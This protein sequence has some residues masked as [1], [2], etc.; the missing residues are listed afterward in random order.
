MKYLVPGQDWSLRENSLRRCRCQSFLS[1][2]CCSCYH[3]H[4]CLAAIPVHLPLLFW[5]KKSMFVF[6]LNLHLSDREA[7]I[8]TVL[9]WQKQLSTNQ[10]HIP[11]LVLSYTHDSQ[12]WV[13]TRLLHISKMKWKKNQAII[14]YFA[15]QNKG[16]TITQHKTK[17]YFSGKTKHKLFLR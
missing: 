2:N 15:V 10:L 1:S 8:F 14:H 3:R 4:C 16:R 5:S 6:H 9:Y 17:N 7:H 13:M 11:L 12:C